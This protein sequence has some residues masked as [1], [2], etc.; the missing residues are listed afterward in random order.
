[1][2][3]VSQFMIFIEAHNT[4]TQSLQYDFSLLNYTE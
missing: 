4:K 3:S 1:M 2:R